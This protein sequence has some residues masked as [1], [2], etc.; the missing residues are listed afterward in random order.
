MLRFGMP[1]IVARHGGAGGNTTAVEGFIRSFNLIFCIGGPSYARVGGA[2]GG[3]PASRGSAARGLA[4]TAAAFW[5]G[6]LRD[7]PSHSAVAAPAPRAL[8]P[9]PASDVI[10]SDSPA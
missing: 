8:A 6:A 4:A 1:N 10:L 9:G 2:V 3:L 5:L 7:A